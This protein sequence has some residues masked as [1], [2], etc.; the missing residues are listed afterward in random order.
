MPSSLR[1]LTPLIQ[2]FDMPRSLAFY[3]DLLGFEVYA[4]SPEVNTGEGCFSHWIW[5]RSGAV[6]LMLNTQYDSNERPAQADASRTATHGDTA[7]FIACE[8]VQAL[9]EQLTSRGL[10]APAPTL[11]PYGIKRFT[12]KDPDG[13]EIV[14]QEV[15]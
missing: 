13:Y 1:G 2:V 15:R 3:R 8:D 7:F 12:I 11:A 14:Y 4:A 5:L 10:K 9:H 6:D